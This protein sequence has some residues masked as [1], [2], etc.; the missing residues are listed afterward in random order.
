MAMR[1]NRG[2]TIDRRRLLSLTGSAA[3]GMAGANLAGWPESAAAQDATP[4]PIQG[5]IAFGQPDRTADVYKPL[6][7]G[8]KL[9]GQARGYEVLES[10]AEGRADKQIA[11]IN[12]WIGSGVKAMTILPLDEKAM[13]PAIEKAHA[14]GIVFVSYSD[15][16][17]NADGYTVFDSVQGGEM[18]GEWVGNW[19]TENSGRRSGDRQPHRRFPRDRTTAHRR[20]GKEDR[21]ARAE[22]EGCQPH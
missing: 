10:F 13:Q 15:I 1:T 5:Q 7:A 3:L 21:R 17:P 22:R 2:S 20:R 4:V 9:E 19:I 8:A 12:N 6:I 18:V 16:I 14:A 11:E